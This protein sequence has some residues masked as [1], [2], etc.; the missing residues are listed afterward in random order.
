MTIFTEFLVK[1]TLTFL[2]AFQFEFLVPPLEEWDHPTQSMSLPP[3]SS[4]CFVDKFYSKRMLL[5]I[6][7][8]L[9]LMSVRRNNVSVQFTKKENRW[10]NLWNIDLTREGTMFNSCLC[11]FPFN[12]FL[13]FLHSFIKFILIFTL[14]NHNKCI[15][16]LLNIKDAYV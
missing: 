14:C 12:N 6:N 5:D 2:L 11:N 1:T 9:K 7:D 15:G 16:K 13:N 4:C 10:F 8:M 3:L